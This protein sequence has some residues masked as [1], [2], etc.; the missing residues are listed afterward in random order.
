MLSKWITGFMFKK[1][2]VD[3]FQDL[4]LAIS[5]KGKISVYALTHKT[6]LVLESNRI[7]V[8]FAC[9]LYSRTWERAP[10]CRLC[11][12]LFYSCFFLYGRL[13][14]MQCELLS[15]FDSIDLVFWTWT[16]FFPWVQTS[17]KADSHDSTLRLGILLRADADC[18]SIQATVTMH[19]HGGFTTISLDD[20]DALLMTS[21][22]MKSEVDSFSM[23]PGVSELCSSNASS[24]HT[25]LTHLS[26]VVIGPSFLQ[27]SPRFLLF[28][29]TLL[30]KKKK[31][32]A[33]PTWH[34]HRVRGL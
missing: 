20:A 4:Y 5:I 23:I 21:A 11:I 17:T 26:Q 24:P 27:L 18:S 8:G 7:R 1:N 14:L 25:G 13:K 9:S 29:L 19:G 6:V 34:V 12:F 30:K 16:F 10:V 31:K 28:R 15:Q 22:C 33:K 3:N 32:K 2:L